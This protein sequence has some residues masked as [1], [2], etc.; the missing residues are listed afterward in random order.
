M[1]HE[2]TGMRRLPAIRID[3]RRYLRRNVQSWC[4]VCGP[5]DLRKEVRRAHI[6]HNSWSDL[7]TRRSLKPGLKYACEVA[8]ELFPAHFVF[9]RIVVLAVE[10]LEL[11]LVL[12]EQVDVDALGLRFFD[13]IEHLIDERLGV[14]EFSQGHLVGVARVDLLQDLLVE[15][16][17]GL[18][19]QGIVL[20]HALYILFRSEIWQN[21]TTA[22]LIVERLSDVF[23]LQGIGHA[24]L[25]LL[26]DFF[27]VAVLEAMVLSVGLQILRGNVELVKHRVAV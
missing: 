1:R 15:V 11:V 12:H 16:F 17:D 22:T 13:V 18:E 20:G 10:L 25:E 7:Q 4:R 21:A 26:L 8:F 6:V 27:D 23:V 9:G 2:K 14:L 3:L 5:I 19:L 24:L